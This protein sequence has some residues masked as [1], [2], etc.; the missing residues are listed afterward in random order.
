MSDVSVVVPCYNHSEFVE[1]CLRSIFAQTHQPEKLFVINDGSTDN[2]AEIIRKVLKDCPFPSE[3]IDQKNS[4]TSAVVNKGFNLSDSK[5]FAY[6]GSDDI[7]LA[8]F[9]EKRIALL[10][11]RPEAVLAF[12]NAYMIDGNDNIFG[13]TTTWG[14]YVDGNPREFLLKANSCASPTV[15]YRSKAV[16]NFKWNE[17]CSVEDLEMYLKLSSIGDF[18]FDESL[19]SGYRVHGTNISQ[20]F[21]KQ[22]QQVL[23]ILDR[24]REILNL[25]EEELMDVKGKLKIGQFDHFILLGYKKKA[26]RLLGES[27]NY[28]EWNSQTVKSLIRLLIPHSY[29][30][31]QSEREKLQNIEKYGKLKY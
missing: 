28:A 3:F 17:D 26:L 6:L 30:K 25:S 29:Y 10:E 1:R 7:W 8:E 21:P 15:V 5:Y 23:E 18:A 13:F 27:L 24:C 4:G 16:E 14:E 19:L 20:D 2:S 9:L 12:G 31:R 22:F 11:K